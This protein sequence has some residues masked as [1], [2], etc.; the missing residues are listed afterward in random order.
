MALPLHEIFSARKYLETYYPID[1][2][3]VDFFSAVQKVREEMQK[4]EKIFDLR[5]FSDE[6][7]L[8]SEV[9]ENAA[10]F[11]FLQTVS[12][13]LL[14]IFP[15]GDAV[16]LD[17]GGGPTL[18]QHI[19][20][21]LNVAAIIHTDFLLENREEMYK[22]LVADDGAY[23]WKNYYLVVQK[24]LRENKQ[25]QSL[26]GT[27]IK[28]EKSDVSEHAKLIQK[29][30]FSPDVEAFEKH[31]RSII[32][33]D[34]ISCD[35]FAPAFEEEGSNSLKHALQ[36]VTREGSPDII[37]AHFLVESATE[38]YEMWE[39][40][41]LHLVEKLSPGGCFVMTAIR[42]ASWYRVGTERVPAVSVNEQSVKK[43]LEEHGIVVEDVQVLIGSNKESH[44]Y[45][46]MIFVFGRKIITEDEK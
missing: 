12:C 34:V 33:K 15:C 14:E 18:Y 1:F 22:Y 24:M 32:V 9:I 42:N 46:G 17:V 10:I 45:D 29:I 4:P 30:L 16:L 20:L 13:R 31:L 39:R 2:N 28:S 44:G 40:G 41:V 5:K 43:F 35:V 11:Y 26:L 3:R 6:I 25:Y 27:Q 23:I 37:S 8:T 21:S 7:N 38:S 36:S 19:P